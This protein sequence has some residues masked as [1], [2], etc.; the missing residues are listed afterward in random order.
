MNYDTVVLPLISGGGRV[1]PAHELPLEVLLFIEDCTSYV[2]R[3]KLPLRIVVLTCGAMGPAMDNTQ[4][5]GF[6]L[7]AATPVRGI[8]RCSRIENPHIP[9]LQ[10]DSDYINEP[11]KGTEIVEQMHAELEL[12]TPPEGFYKA[13][14][15]S[16][17]RS[18]VYVSREVAYR[19]GDR[20]LGKL[21][22]CARNPLFS[23]ASVAPL[24]GADRDGVA[25]ITGGTGGLGLVTAEALVEMGV[26]NIVLSSRSGRISRGNQGLDVRL[27]AIRSAGVRLELFACDV[28]VEESV[29]D[30]LNNVREKIG[31]IAHV[32]NAAGIVMPQDPSMMEPTYQPKVYGAFFMH[33]HTLQDDIK[34]FVFY[35]SMSAGAG[36]NELHNYASANTYCDELSKWRQHHGLPC[37]SIQFPEVEDAGMAADSVQKGGPAN[38][39]TGPVKQTFKLIVGGSGPIGPVTPIM[40]KGYL[41]PRTVVMDSMLSLLRARMDENR[42]LAM[43]EEEKKYGRDGPPA[44]RML[45]GY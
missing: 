9:I 33:K 25:I 7:P 40:V 34:T 6:L 42:W 30:F 39:G 15:E 17:N 24:A 44:R 27:E 2:N 29:V 4:D 13:S 3:N 41:I 1:R 11:G 18:I 32:F 28:G 22:L 38:V 43:A 21:D 20:Y 10:I 36:A 45:F 12:S 8:L 37:V 26:K 23:G 14:I 31:P 19:S 16:Q 35:S 5:D